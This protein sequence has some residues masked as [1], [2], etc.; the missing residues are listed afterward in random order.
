[1]GVTHHYG[2]YK[3]VH[4]LEVGRCGGFNTG[5]CFL[6]FCGQIEVLEGGSRKK[7]GVVFVRSHQLKEKHFPD[8]GET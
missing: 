3:R 8:E 6:G 7:H 2:S 1:M 5:Y 4:A